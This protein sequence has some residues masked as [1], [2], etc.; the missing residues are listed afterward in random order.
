MEQR[1]D[2]GGGVL[3]AVPDAVIEVD[4][5]GRIERVDARAE[6][7]F[8]WPAGELVGTSIDLLVADRLAQ[9]GPR[10]DGVDL[11]LSARRRDGSRFPAE[12]RLSPVTGEAGAPLVA[13]SIRDAST[14]AE[15]APGDEATALASVPRVNPTV[16]DL[17]ALASSVAHDLNNSLSVIMIYSDLI[18]RAREHR[19]IDR[20]LAQIRAAAE[21]GTELTGQ[22]AELARRSREDPVVVPD[23]APARQDENLLLRAIAMLTTPEAEHETIGV[24]VVDDHVMFAEGLALLL[25]SEDDIE[26][27]G[28]GATG[29]E[30][31]GLVDRLRPRVLLLDFDMPGGNGVLAA[32][33]VKA[34][35]PDTMIV[36]VSGSSDERLLLRAI[37]AGCS[38]YL[39]KDR[40][41]AEVASA[42]RAVAAGEAL[43][44]PAQMARLLP[45]L[46]RSNL[47]RGSD[48][49]ARELDVLALL[50]RG[51][52]NQAIAAEI[53]LPVD[54]VRDDVEQIFTKLG[55]HSKLEAVATAIRE[56]LIDYNSPF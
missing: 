47:G 22:L 51:A 10:P 25:G 15:P 40:A 56:E 9:P 33:E 41:A 29:R 49:T 53:S 39:T 12:I 54:T 35:W 21:R 18:E 34:K 32:S 26:V 3:A 5:G 1:D 45:R 2:A 52:T 23:E 24:V 55:A 42:V 37:E 11:L 16:H 38:G 50:S 27:L 48:L 30:A 13:V 46:S 20:D 44:S 7:L 31:V 43:I 17:G 36:M 4:P 6:Q 19:P 28:V 14:G 8:G